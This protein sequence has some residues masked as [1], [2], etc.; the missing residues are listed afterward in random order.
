MVAN[1]KNNN[2]FQK[3]FLLSLCSNDQNTK[4]VRT[5]LKSPLELSQMIVQL[6]FK[7]NF[8][9][10]KDKLDSIKQFVAGITRSEALGKSY[11]LAK[12]YPYLFSFHHPPKI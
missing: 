2:T 8:K 3:R 9:E 4:T 6:L 5:I 11:S 1:M 10:I 7:N 12:F